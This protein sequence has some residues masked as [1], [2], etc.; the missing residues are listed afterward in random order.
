MTIRALMVLL[1]AGTVLNGCDSGGTDGEAL[2]G[3]WIR[4]RTAT[5]KKDQFL[6]GADGAFA[7]DENKPDAPGEE[8]HLT[9]TYVAADGV[10]T[11]T[12]SDAS[13]ALARLT[14]SYYANTTQFSAAALHP[15]TAHTGIVGT[16]TGVQKVELLDGSGQNPGGITVQA[17]FRADRT[18]RATITY[19]DGTPAFVNEGTWVGET[20]GTFHGVGDGPG[21]TLVLLDDQ[22]LVDPYQ[23]W[24]RN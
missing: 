7:F 1:V 8:D 12:A 3:S 11:A 6:F 13:G 24:Q 20:D 10:V 19:L 16:W 22:A 17:Q 23:I 2:V 21:F 5:E 4:M 15:T 18:Y 14:F 9:G